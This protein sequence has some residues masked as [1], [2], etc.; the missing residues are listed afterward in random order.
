[1]Q[2]KGFKVNKAHKAAHYNAQGLL[3][4]MQFNNF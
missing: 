4:E 2:Q 1:M 3:L